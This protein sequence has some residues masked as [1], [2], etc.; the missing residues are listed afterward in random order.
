MT[1]YICEKCAFTTHIKT[2]YNTHL[3]TD[4]HK[5]KCSTLAQQLMELKI[6]EMELK[7]E[8]KMKE[9]ETK[10][11][12]KRAEM[13]QKQELKLKE[14]ELKHQ[15]KEEAKKKEEKTISYH[16]LEGQIGCRQLEEQ[17]VERST[18]EDYSDIFHGLMTFEELFM[19]DFEAE[20]S[21][22]K[23]VVLEPGH[24]SGYYLNNH[25]ALWP[26]DNIID[27]RQALSIIKLIPKYHSI[28]KQFAK[29]N[30]HN[31]KD[32]FLS[33]EEQTR[34]EDQVL[35]RITYIVT[36]DKSK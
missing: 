19:R 13:E 26:M 22:N 4:K 15:M 2:H 1:N 21:M 7:N 8:T 14:I 28:L 23:S 24:K 32:F 31:T 5:L 20:Y 17:I 36:Y 12:I 16:S 33:K 18:L 10:A 27:P 29:D 34:I 6:K 11:E 9:M 25:P 30:G 3:T 35:D